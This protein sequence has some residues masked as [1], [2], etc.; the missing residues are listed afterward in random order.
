M[1]LFLGNTLAIFN[2]KSTAGIFDKL[3]QGLL[4]INMETLHSLSDALRSLKGQHKINCI[5]NYKFNYG[6]T[7]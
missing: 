4:E 3:I 6:V 1:L 7:E 2:S 5:I